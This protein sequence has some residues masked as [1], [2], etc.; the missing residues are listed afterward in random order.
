MKLSMRN[1]ERWT[2]LYGKMH[3]GKRRCEELRYWSRPPIVC[4]LYVLA[5]HRAAIARNVQTH[6]KRGI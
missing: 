2:L 4:W 1:G 6:I 5:Q 3:K